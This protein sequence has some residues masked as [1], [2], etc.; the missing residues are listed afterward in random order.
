MIY[1]LK[2]VGVTITSDLTWQAHVDYT[3]KRV[4]GKIWQL[5][6]FRQL[7]AS[8]E[9][10]T[11]FYILKIRSILM[12]SSVC[13]HHY[14][15]QEQ[16]Q[17]LEMQQKRSLAVI[18]G[19]EYRSYRNSLSLTSLPRL[20]SLHTDLFPLNNSQIAT[21]KHSRNTPAQLQSFTRV[22]YLP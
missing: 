12:F 22:L 5:V 17:K 21:R 7:G 18:L 3:V 20:D 9:K 2:L 4:N 10:L 1:Q 16:S 14:L 19:T 6:R 11:Q 13:F 8:R 15:T